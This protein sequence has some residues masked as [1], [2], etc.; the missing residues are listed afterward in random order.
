MQD[1]RGGVA[2]YVIQCP[3][4]SGSLKIFASLASAYSLRHSCSATF[5]HPLPTRLGEHARGHEAAARAAIMGVSVALQRWKQAARSRQARLPYVPRPRATCAGPVGLLLL[6]A[7]VPKG[8]PTTANNARL[9]L[10]VERQSRQAFTRRRLSAG[11]MGR[12]L[13]TTAR[14]RRSSRTSRHAWR[15]KA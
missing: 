15:C 9:V 2:R 1:R 5:N 6:C 3:R 11:S 10:G 13:S 4:G 7:I 12:W 14:D 8:N